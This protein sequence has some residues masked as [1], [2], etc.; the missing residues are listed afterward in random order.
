MGPF[1]LHGS[2]N[3]VP[4]APLSLLRA[5]DVTK[6]RSQQQNA[7]EPIHPTAGVLKVEVLFRNVVYVK[8]IVSLFAQC[9]TPCVY[10]ILRLVNPNRLYHKSYI[11]IKMHTNIEFQNNNICVCEY[12]YTP[13]G[14]IAFNCC[15]LSIRSN[16]HYFRSPPYFSEFNNI[17]STKSFHLVQILFHRL[18]ELVLKI[19]KHDR[20]VLQPLDR[21]VLLLTSFSGRPQPIVRDLFGNNS[22]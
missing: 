6:L 17:S 2:R 18:L 4:V 14:H 10:A 13:Q 8:I 21:R 22:A 19:G 5:E 7:S 16:N 9:F 12:V 11:S 20:S 1:G 15:S 3:V